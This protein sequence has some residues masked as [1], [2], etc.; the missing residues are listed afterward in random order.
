[1]YMTGRISI[2]GQVGRG[3][4]I[5]GVREEKMPSVIALKGIQSQERFVTGLGPKL[6]GTFE[7]TLI[8]AAGRLDGAATHGFIALTHIT[9][10]KAAAI[11][12]DVADGA[13]RVRTSTL[14]LTQH[15]ILM[16]CDWQVCRA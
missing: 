16:L 7:A 12:F 13:L 15:I 11:V 4:E 2:S 3:V 8:L 6:A 14:T 1:M 9:I 10:V 5:N